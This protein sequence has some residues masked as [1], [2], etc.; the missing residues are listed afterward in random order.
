MTVVLTASGLALL[1]ALAVIGRR[2]WVRWRYPWTVH[3]VG[4][5]VD[6]T[7]SSVTFTRFRSESEA[8]AWCREE[9]AQLPEWMARPWKPVPWLLVRGPEV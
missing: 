9:N 2:T 3:F 6:S 1:A 7:R 4:R 8:A 5:Y